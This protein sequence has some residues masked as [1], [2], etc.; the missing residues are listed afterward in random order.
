MATVVLAGLIYVK[1]EIHIDDCN[2]F[3][4][5]M[6]EQVFRLRIIFESF[7]KHKIFMKANKWFLGMPKSTTLATSYLLR[8]LAC[9]QWNKHPTATPVGNSVFI[10]ISMA[11][12]KSDV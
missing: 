2:V 12:S 9:F 6:D 11:C 10:V 1:C 5:G 4:K 7:R 8:E 3:A